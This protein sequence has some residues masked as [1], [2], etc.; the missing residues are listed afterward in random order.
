MTVALSKYDWGEACR[1]FRGFKDSP[2]AVRL[3]WCLCEYYNEAARCAYPTR[4]TLALE[5]DA[6]AESIS[7]WMKT[8]VQGGAVTCVPIGSL[9]PEIRAIVGRSAKRAQVYF[10][11]FGWAIDVLALKDELRANR[12]AARDQKVTVSPPYAER[13]GNG[14]ATP[15][16]NDTVTS[17]GGGTVTL[18]PYDQTLDHTLKERGRDGSESSVYAREPNGYAHAKG[19]AA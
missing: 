11:N 18:I 17:T 14:S 19:R 2:G 10:L 7:K 16:G 6:P 13:K 12:D 4:E 15:K 3:S 5:L 8:L 1:F 9:P